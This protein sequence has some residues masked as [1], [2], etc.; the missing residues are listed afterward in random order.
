MQR[1]KFT[2]NFPFYALMCLLVLPI[3]PLTL[4]K[5][6]AS[7]LT[8]IIVLKV[9]NSSCPKAFIFAFVTCR[10]SERVGCSPKVQ[11]ELE[12]E[13]SSVL[14]DSNRWKR[15][16][17]K[18]KENIFERVYAWEFCERDTFKNRKC[19]LFC[20]VANRNVTAMRLCRSRSG[21]VW[22]EHRSCDSE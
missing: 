12:F 2:I 1:V 9:A 10:K 18:R 14:A 17:Y 19:F 16:F 21:S 13:R 22:P 6:I 3:T 20:A 8:I 7:I 11:R 15:W 5:I 4:Y